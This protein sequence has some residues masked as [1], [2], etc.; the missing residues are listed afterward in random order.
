MSF[1]DCDFNISVLCLIVEI[2]ESEL[3]NENFL[4][5][6]YYDNFEFDNLLDII[7]YKINYY[8]INIKNYT[9]NVKIDK[10]LFRIF[11]KNKNR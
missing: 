4:E 7:I 5:F 1:I 3:I 8:K 2:L 11:L 10:F 9:F 6:S